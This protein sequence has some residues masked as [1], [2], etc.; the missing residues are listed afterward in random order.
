MLGGRWL[1][2]QPVPL[3]NRWQLIL[4]PL[5]YEAGGVLGMQLQPQ[6]TP[7]ET[8]TPPL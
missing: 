7:V 6:D 8:L 1:I 4:F 3:R 2:K 5:F